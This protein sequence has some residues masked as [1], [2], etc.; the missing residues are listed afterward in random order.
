MSYT[1]KINGAS[2]NVYKNGRQIATKGGWGANASRVIIEGDFVMCIMNNGRVKVQRISS[3]HGG[4]F[5]S[6]DSANIWI[7]QQR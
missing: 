6:L 5:G 7:K 4:E 1:A 3:S 2:V